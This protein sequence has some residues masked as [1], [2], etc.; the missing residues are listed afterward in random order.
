MQKEAKSETLKRLNRIAGQVR[1]LA[2]MVEDD[3][4]CIDI[5]TQLSAVRAALRKVEDAILRDH[6]GH[7]VEGAIKSG[8]KAEQRKKVAELMDVFARAE[9]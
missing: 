9:R 4:Y 5:L 6:V 8:D 2:G 3:R 7:C 1:G